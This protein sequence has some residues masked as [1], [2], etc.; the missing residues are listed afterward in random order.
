MRA[1][2]DHA[3]EDMTTR[4]EDAGQKEMRPDQPGASRKLWDRHRE[5]A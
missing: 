2:W 3:P 4:Q 1:D 5:G